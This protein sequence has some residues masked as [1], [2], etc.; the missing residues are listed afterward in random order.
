MTAPN[1]NTSS[2]VTNFSN[3]ANT[4]TSILALTDQVKWGSSGVGTGATA[5]FSFPI[6]NSTALWNLAYT[7]NTNSEIYNNFTPFSTAQQTAAEQALQAWAN[8]A[9][10][11]FIK[12]SSETSNS[13]GDIRF[14]NTSGGSM[15]SSTYAY[16]SFPALNNPEGGDIWFNF[17]QPT[18]SANDYSIGA[19]GYQTMIHEIGHALGLDHPFEGTTTLTTALDN[20]QYTV[21]SY[22]DAP[23]NQ[24]AG[25]STYY[26]TTP[27]L[28]DIQ[29]IQYLYGANTSYHNGN[30]TYVYTD[31]YAYE[32][33]WDT[34]GIDTIQ[35]T[36][37]M[38]ASINL[39]S[40]EFS[41]L[42]PSVKA[43]L[44]VSAN[45][46]NNIAIAYN[47]TIENAIG[48]S[49]SDTFYGNS[50]SNTI[51]GGEGQDT[52]ITSLQK[53]ALDAV[54]K[55]SEAEIILS[56]NGERDT[57]NS[58]ETITFSDGTYTLA[59]LLSEASPEFTFASNGSTSLVTPESYSGP[60]SYLEYQLLGTAS[61]ESVIGAFSNDFFNLGGGNDA[62]NGGGGQ[63]VIDGGTGSNFLTGGGDADTFFL[64][65]R[66]GE[67]TWS[68]ITDFNGDT[69]TIWG[70]IDGTSQILI[71]R[72][73][74]ATGYEGNTL[75]LDLDG[76]NQIDTSITF[77]GLSS[78]Q[79]ANQQAG[80][81][82]GNSYLIIS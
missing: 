32:T 7:A 60:V 58:V 2:P 48:S 21:M 26:P 31:S 19:N 55:T 6:S 9:N 51:E 66:S 30:N 1:I 73:D 25:N 23:N 74:G 67:T 8:V 78:A 3:P 33:I 72:N 71:E 34:G 46:Q 49:G 65:G 43:H 12:V 81:I 11:T 70:W 40:G 80:V 47:V 5:Y 56:A 53:S 37:T 64:D 24:D 13:V 61:D 79:T 38:D 16:A 39:N 82:E 10:L 54:I 62:A 59:N 14:G 52:F 75:H 36:G 42:G 41:S 63:D 15:D 44:G 76:N 68:T 17:T 20:M 4:A 22:S 29:A 28:L 69:V 50:A 45:A 18:A 57:L 35:Y 27:M 77:T